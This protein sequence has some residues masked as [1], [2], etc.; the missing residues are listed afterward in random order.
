MCR[1]NSHGGRRC[2]N[3]TSEARRLRRHN[4]EAMRKFAEQVQPQLTANPIAVIEEVPTLDI[5]HVKAKIDEL[6][7]LR[8]QLRELI[9]A[10]PAPAFLVVV[11]GEKVSF[12][13]KTEGMK[14][15][16]AAQEQKVILIGNDISEL[17]S[18]RSGI[19]A[20]AIHD[21]VKTRGAELKDLIEA[22]EKDPVLLKALDDANEEYTQ[23]ASQMRA[24][25][26]YDGK[27]SDRDVTAMLNHN[28]NT[29]DEAYGVDADALSA[30]Y[31][32]YQAAQSNLWRV[33]AP[34]LDEARTLLST[35]GRGNPVITEMLGKQ[36]AA[37]KEVLG[38]I[39]EFG[40]ELVVADNSDK[41]R[42]KILQSI[43]DVYPTDWIESSNNRAPVRVKNSAGRAHYSDR[44]PQDK[45]TV[46]QKVSYIVKPVDWEPDPK[47]P[48]DFGFRRASEIAEEE[49]F[50]GIS[51]RRYSSNSSQGT[52]W[53]G[54]RWEQFSAYRHNSRNGVPIGRG[55]VKQ[56]IHEDGGN[57]REIWFKPVME[58][59]LESTTIQAELTVSD[60]GSLLFPE[61]KGHSTAIHEFAHRIE[62]SH[63][64]FI[65]QMEEEFLKRRTTD[66]E[67]QTRQKL[68]TLY[69]GKKEYARTD[70]FVNPY[71]GKEYPNPTHREVLSTGMEAVF[72]GNYG[73]LVGAGDTNPDH[74]MKHFILGLLASA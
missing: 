66:A 26:G 34:Y 27:Y 16:L 68:T 58:R 12:P 70:N 36:V 64:A 56:E 55:W 41:A 7:G 14:A 1:D 9:E 25:Y 10:P 31:Q 71:M 33:K 32:T 11:N 8:E 44:R 28:K 35:T 47:N 65:P 57:V 69:K 39:R 52:V 72:G 4:S 54:P 30:A 18:M 60:G 59:K 73:G 3:D 2:P 43:M 67:T 23:L 50:S 45:Y 38:E 74:D 6:N 46:K 15:L 19:S 51:M 49:E 13:N 62:A 24:K 5:S 21:Y 53:V 61:G 48:T 42:V 17:A 20:E 63:G 40:G 37:Y 22:T 29:E